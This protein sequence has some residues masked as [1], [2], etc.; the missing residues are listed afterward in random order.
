MTTITPPDLH[1]SIHAATRGCKDDLLT[2]SHAIHAL[3]E[4]GFEE[5]EVIAPAQR[6]HRGPRIY[7]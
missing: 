6:I 3:A 1:T 4:I 7:S 5:F 2:A